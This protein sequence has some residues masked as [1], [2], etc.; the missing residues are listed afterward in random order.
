MPKNISFTA[1][2]ELH[3]SLQ[4]LANEHERSLASLLR[5]VCV[6]ALKEKP[7]LKSH[8]FEDDENEGEEDTEEMGDEANDSPAYIQAMLK[9]G[10]Q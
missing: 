4:A 3:A 8:S 9:T 1:S 7:E 2:D 6:K 10:K 5:W